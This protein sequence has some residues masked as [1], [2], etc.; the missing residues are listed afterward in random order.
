MGQEKKSKPDNKKQS[1][2][3]VETA[4][5]IKSDNDKEK[6][7]QACKKIFIRKKTKKT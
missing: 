1:A 4:E 2:R 7:E 5:R 6:F 3:F